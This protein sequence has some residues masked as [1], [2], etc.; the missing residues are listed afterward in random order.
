MIFAQAAVVLNVATAKIVNVV[1][2]A[3][4]DLPSDANAPRRETPS[5]YNENA[6]LK[7]DAELA[8]AQK[9]PFS[10]KNALS[11]GARASPSRFVDAK[12]PDYNDFNA[13]SQRRFVGKNLSFFDSPAPARAFFPFFRLG[14]GVEIRARP[15]FLGRSL[16]NIRN[17]LA[18]APFSPEKRFLPFS[19]GSRLDANRPLFLLSPI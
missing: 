9:T 15:C 1:P 4:A 18:A 17:I 16:Y 10:R 2:T 8:T 5:L 19:L 6:P 7:T 12:S 11:F 14:R 13:L 3:F